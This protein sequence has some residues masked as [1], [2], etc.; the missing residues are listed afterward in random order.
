MKVKKPTSRMS[1]E[2]GQV[3]KLE[4]GTCHIGEVGKRLVHYKLL[5]GDAT[6]GYMSLS[7]V[8]TLLQHLK[9]KKAV[10]V[11]NHRNVFGIEVQRRNSIQ[12]RLRLQG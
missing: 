12:P 1:I 10:L 5:K 3:W 11:H 9:A 6:R 8:E 4:G 2:A 7:N